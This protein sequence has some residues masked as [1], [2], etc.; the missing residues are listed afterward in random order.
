[1]SVIEAFFFYTKRKLE[2]KKN[3]SDLMQERG[4][5]QTPKRRGKVT[6]KKI[7]QMKVTFH[8]HICIPK[9]NP[10]KRATN[11]KP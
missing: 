7:N 9:K 11:R 3:S 4:S 1:M 8:A 5:T 10:V 6:K 2:A